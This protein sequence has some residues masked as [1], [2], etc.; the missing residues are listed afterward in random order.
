MYSGD[1]KDNPSMTTRMA[2]VEERLDKI[3]V[4]LGTMSKVMVGVIVAVI[5]QV[6]LR[7]LKLL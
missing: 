4:L 7:F 1:G 6:I 5:A 2:L 3:S